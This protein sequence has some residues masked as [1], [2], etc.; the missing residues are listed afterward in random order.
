MFSNHQRPKGICFKEGPFVVV[1]IKEIQTAEE[2]FASS[3]A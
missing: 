3:K 2:R 1:R